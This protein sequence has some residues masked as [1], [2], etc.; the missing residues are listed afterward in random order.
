MGAVLVYLVGEGRANEHREPH[1]VA[2]EASVLAWHG[3]A[4]LDKQAALEIARTLDGS[5]RAFG[6]RVTTAVKDPQGN[7]CGQ[8]DAHV[9]HCSLNL[10]AEEGELPDER[11]ARISE[12]FV[13]AL[14][15]AGEQPCRWAA[16]RHGLS[17]KGNDHV[18]LVVSLVREDGTKANVWNDRPRA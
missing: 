1:L 11:W 13:E 10:A 6:T 9:W 8:R 15:F 2:G 4:E 3:D 12:Q 5:R 17:T 16:V 7:R 18:H 14:G